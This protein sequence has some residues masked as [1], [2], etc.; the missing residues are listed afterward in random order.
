MTRSRLFTGI[1]T[2]RK[3]REEHGYYIDKTAYV[4]ELLDMGTHYFLFRPRRFSKSLFLDTRHWGWMWW[5]KTA[6]ATGDWT[7]RYV[8][9]ATSTSSSSKLSTSQRRGRQWRN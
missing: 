3:I 4:R 1:Q 7:W 6:A 5:S 9:P 8:S 2:F